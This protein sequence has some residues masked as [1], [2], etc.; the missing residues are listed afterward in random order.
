MASDAK[1]SA[2]AASSRKLAASNEM[3]PSKQPP[4]HWPPRV[5]WILR[6]FY[7]KTITMSEYD[8]LRTVGPNRPQHLQMILAGQCPL[9]NIVPI[10]TPSHPA[11]DQ[12]GLFA[13]KNLPPDTFIISYLGFVHL[14]QESD[15]NSNYDLSL[16]R[17]LGIGIDATKMGNEARMI[18]D[19]RGVREKGP[20]A[21]FRDV[22][23]IDEGRTEKRIAVYVLS[24]GKS[25]K[26][27]KGIAKG[28]EILVSYG[29]GF[30]NKRSATDANEKPLVI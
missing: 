21:E 11:C 29:K 6:P 14:A 4:K 22:W 19:Y 17:D 2:R 26:R 13:A 7:S 28:E 24:A 20:N 15:P 8:A 30:W 10:T 16:D 18:N 3:W 9:V 12:Y 27:A 23:V 5:T 1:R 25:G